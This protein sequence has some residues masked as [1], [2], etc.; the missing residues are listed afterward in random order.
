MELQENVSRDG[1]GGTS[2]SG[3]RKSYF[4]TKRLADI[5]ASSILL[6][7]L[8]PLI[9]FLWYYLRKK[10]GSPVFFRQQRIG[11][12]Q[13]PFILWRFRT[14]TVPSRVIRSLPPHPD[15]EPAEGGFSY[16]KD[17]TVTFTITGEKLYKHDL[18][19]L[20]ELWH[21]L[22][23]DMSLIGPNPAHPEMAVHYTRAQQRRFAV[24]P[25]MISCVCL[26]GGLAHHK[27]IKHELYYIR[28]CCHRLDR[29][30][31]LQSMKRFGLSIFQS[32]RKRLL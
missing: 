16:Q 3:K 13:A 29:K 9:F 20:P 15:Y 2:F 23:G 21:V 27:K 31:L 17:P 10:E 7:V 32:A 19:K 6:L 1:Q 5:A 22:K 12:N 28:H 30:I 11:R 25:G 18:H 14:M 8:M 24:K 26:Q 4:I